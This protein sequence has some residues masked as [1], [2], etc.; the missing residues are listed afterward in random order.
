MVRWIVIAIYIVLGI[1]LV[2]PLPGRI[3][4]RR[5]NPQ[6]PAITLLGYLGLLLPL[7]WIVAL[8][9]SVWNFKSTATPSTATPSTAT[10]EDA[11]VYFNKGVALE[12]VGRHKEAI[13]AY[14]SA[15]MARPDYAEAYKSMGKLMAQLGL[16]EEAIEAY[17]FADAANPADAD[18]EAY[19]NSGLALENLGQ[20]TEAADA[21]KQAISLDP[22]SELAQSVKL[23]L[24]D[25]GD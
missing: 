22:D 4:R 9:M 13:A 16:H 2:G 19:F 6:T 1:F 12:K 7:L 21:Y 18:A 8:I 25:H 14:R 3:A 11:A 15:V 5:N 20:H 24:K 10:P 23:R 17:R